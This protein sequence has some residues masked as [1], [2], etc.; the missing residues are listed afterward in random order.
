LARFKIFEEEQS[1]FFR[2]FED[3]QEYFADTT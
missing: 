3:I 1:K 2:L